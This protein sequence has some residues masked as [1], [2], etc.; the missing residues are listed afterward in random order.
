MNVYDSER[1][2]VMLKNSGWTPTEEPSEAELVIINSCSVRE[3]PLLKLFSCAGRYLPY[4]KKTGLKIFITGCVAQ[5]LGKETLEKA[6]YIDGVFGPGAE[7]MIPEVLEKGVFPFVSNETDLLERE[8]IF[9]PGSRGNVFSMHTA[10]ITVMHGCDNYCSYC[11]VPY[12]RGREVSRKSKTL[13]D[14]IKLLCDNGVLEIT[15]L[16]QNVNSYRD[17]ETGMDFT[18]LLHSISQNTSVKRIRFVTSHPKDFGEKLAEA[19]ASIPQLTP[20]LHLP[21]QSGSDRILNA[22]NRKYTVSDYLKKIDLS[23]KFCP[24][25]ALSSD[26]IVGFPGETEQDFDL[27]MELVEKADYDVI[28]A[29]NYSPRPLTK[30]YAFEDDVPGTVKFE[31]LNRLLDLQRKKIKEVRNRYLGRTTSVLVENKSPKGESFMG[32]T[33]HN[34]ITH[35]INSSSEDIGKIINV[36]IREILEN[37]LR[38]EKYEN[39]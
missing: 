31:R 1:M 30:A 26:F 24:D 21:A 16:G 29:F 18:D 20:Y 28:F 10:S 2:T 27:T 17:P 6:P 19:F 4:K 5:Q 12:V 3:K 34:L 33:E 36:R 23:R 37:T 38:G 11:I 7:Y 9:P 35:I 32:R 15:L 22:M 13:L 14:E 25:I 8:E 39:R